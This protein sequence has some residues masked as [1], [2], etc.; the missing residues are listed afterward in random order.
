MKYY[1]R[2]LDQVIKLGQPGV[3]PYQAYNPSTAKWDGFPG[4]KAALTSNDGAPVVTQ[5]NV[6]RLVTALASLNHAGEAAKNKSKSITIGDFRNMTQQNQLKFINE[7]WDLIATPFAFDTKAQDMYVPAAAGV[8]PAPLPSSWCPKPKEGMGS[9]AVHHM[10]LAHG[11]HPDPWKRFCVGFRVDGSDM[12]SIT[13][14]RTSGMTQQILNPS[15]MLN[16]RGMVVDGT[17][18]A[19]PT[20]PR[21]WTS[22]DDIFN[23][24]A[25]C[26][27]RNFFGGTAFPLRNSYHHYLSGPQGGR[28][29]ETQFSV[30]WAVDCTGLVGMDTEAIQLR[31]PGAR[32]WRPG[33][34]AFREI[35]PNRLIGYI[36]IRKMGD[37]PKGGWSFDIKPG[38]VWTYCGAGSFDQKD[39]INGELKAWTGCHYIPGAFDFAT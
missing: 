6:D 25:V 5:Q 16:F 32:V 26:V 15:F 11:G 4:G 18:A 3:K 13:R 31:R 2:K 1:D 36:P 27:S 22:N 19:D 28:K 33:E 30:L 34:K 38:T 7:L 21:F 20:K 8:P 24:T 14:V 23:E 35:R 9:T 37:S 29:G 12:N 17:T 39:Y 10:R